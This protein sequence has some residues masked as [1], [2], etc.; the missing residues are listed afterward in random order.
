MC[1]EEMVSKRDSTV[2][3]QDVGLPVDIILECTH[4]AYLDLNHSRQDQRPF[5]ASAVCT[6]REYKRRETIN[7]G[8]GKQFPSSETRALRICSRVGIL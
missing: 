5:F 2:Y 6:N 1:E 4:P 3:L 8:A 7:L